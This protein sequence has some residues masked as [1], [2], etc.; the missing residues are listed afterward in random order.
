MSY[1]FHYNPKFTLSGFCSF[2]AK[3][4]LRIQILKIRGNYS[5][6]GTSFSILRELFL[7]NTF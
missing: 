1:H 3:S 6:A 2:T 4:I 5:H 7:S